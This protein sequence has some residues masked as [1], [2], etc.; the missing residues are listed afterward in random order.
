MTPQIEPPRIPAQF[1]SDQQ[2]RDL[3]ARLDRIEYHQRKHHNRGRIGRIILFPFKAFGLAVLAA[4]LL[5]FA[6][7]VIG[8]A[9]VAYRHRSDL[10]K[11]LHATQMAHHP[12]TSRALW[13]PRPGPVRRSVY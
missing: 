1:L 12:R 10:M 11:G 6:V 9:T 5:S 7:G 4:L 3:T 8:L 2:Y 13:R